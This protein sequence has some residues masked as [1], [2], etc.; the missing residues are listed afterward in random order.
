MN[1]N[2]LAR[3]Y[4]F[5]S[6]NAAAELAKIDSK[7]K[8]YAIN[9]ITKKLNKVQNS[10]NHFSPVKYQKYTD[11]KDNLLPPG[12]FVSDKR[13]VVEGNSAA[14]SERD[15]KSEFIRGLLV[16]RVGGDNKCMGDENAAMNAVIN[17]SDYINT[18]AASITDACNNILKSDMPIL[19]EVRRVTTGL[20]SFQKT[21]NVELNTPA[22]KFLATKITDEKNFKAFGNIEG[23]DDE[24]LNKVKDCVR[25]IR[26][27]SSKISV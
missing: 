22:T 18:L 25:E 20:T 5:K 23:Y 16:D 9:M 10:T 8:D 21:I 6:T 11:L 26:E 27:W 2:L 17:S 3:A 15:E 1:I 24:T 14:R 13:E 12:C 7:H 19:S 4:I